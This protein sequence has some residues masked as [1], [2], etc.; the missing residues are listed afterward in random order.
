MSRRRLTAR[1]LGRWLRGRSDL[2][3]LLG[4]SDDDR[5]ELIWQ[6]HRRVAAGRL[7][8]AD[9]LFG[10]LGQLWP[11]AAPTARLG[12]GVCLQ[13]LGDLAGAERAYDDCLRDE[14]ENIHALAN[15]AE[16]RLLARRPDAAR[17]DLAAALALLDRHGGPADL[18]RR[19]E[20]LKE[21]SD[22]E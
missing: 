16:C 15:R 18:R 17:A 14:P 8:E 20:A 3:G 9:R 10:L 2:A 19:V 1:R 11:T 4:L 12:Q 7:D 5:D 6:A 21:L 13:A 22:Q